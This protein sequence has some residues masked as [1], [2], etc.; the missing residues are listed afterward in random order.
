[1]AKQKVLMTSITGNRD[2]QFI[3]GFEHGLAER[4]KPGSPERCLWLAVLWRAVLDAVS[5]SEEALVWFR[6][7]DDRKQS[8]EWVCDIL[9]IEQP[10]KIRKI[11]MSE[12]ARKT[13]SKQLHLTKILGFREGR[14]DLEN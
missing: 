10:N 1:M 4:I 2:N 8:F 13:I 3:G 12:T 7:C 6:R 11:I 9:D 14:A 5:G